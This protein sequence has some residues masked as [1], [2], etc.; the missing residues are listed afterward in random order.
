[1]LEQACIDRNFDGP[2]I[3]RDA[4]ELSEV[5]TDEIPMATTAY[6]GKARVPTDIDI[7]IAGT[8]CVDFSPLN[9]HKKTLSDDGESADTWKAPLSFCKAFRPAIVLLENVRDAP[10]DRMLDEYK[11]IGYETA[12][13]KIDTKNYYLPQTRQRGYMVCFDATRT[14]DTGIQSPGALWQSLMRKHMRL[15]SSPVSSFLLPTEQLTVNDSG[16]IDDEAKREVDWDVCK[17]SHVHYRQRK[18]LGTARPLTHWQESGTMIVPENASKSWYQSQTERVRDLMDCS[19]LRKQREM[20]DFRF[21][22]RILNTTQNL[23]MSED[24]VPFG[25]IECITPRGQYYITDAARVLTAEETMILQGLPMDRI[26]FTTET[27]TEVRDLAGNA[28]SSPTI[29][30]AMISA[31]I[32]GHKL[33]NRACEKMTEGGLPE[34]PDTT[35][36]LPQTTAVESI[37]GN[38]GT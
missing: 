36:H 33:F 5:V 24:S 34:R 35:L 11:H 20:C 15:A 7:I 14:R 37:S 26:S 17:E 3:F 2:L 18:R 12:G 21:K 22:T 32:S 29:G 19:F 28:M 1:M 23:H 38:Q 31:L 8:S 13:V 16:R 6:G 30:I 27:Q 4:T 10:W 9:K 25:I